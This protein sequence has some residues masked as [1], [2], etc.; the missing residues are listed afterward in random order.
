M[1]ACMHM[2]MHMHMRALPQPSHNLLAAADST[3]DSVIR[4]H[5]ILCVAAAE[6]GARGRA[7]YLHMFGCH[8]ILLHAVP[9]PGAT[10]T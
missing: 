10:C 5:A 2:H 1:H 3:C 8:Y 4:G 6:R 9:P 7:V